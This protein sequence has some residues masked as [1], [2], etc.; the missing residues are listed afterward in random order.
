MT[1]QDYFKNYKKTSKFPFAFIS[2]D[3][4]TI[5]NFYND[6]IAPI[7]SDKAI[8]ANMIKWHQMLVEYSKRNN[9]YWVR[10]YESG[11]ANSNDNRRASLV[12]FNDGFKIL[13]VSNFDAQEIL[14][15][16]IMGV[17]PDLNEFEKLMK[18]HEYYF[19]YSQSCAENN[20]NSYPN[21]L[22]AKKLGVLT[23]AKYYLAHIRSV[24]EH[25][26]CINGM[27]YD[28][29]A[30]QNKSLHDHLYPKG[31]ETDYKIEKGSSYRVY[32]VDYSLN[33]DEKAIIKAHFLRFVDPLNYFP[34]PGENNHIYDYSD[35]SS[36]Y[37]NIGEFPFLISYMYDKMTSIFSGV[38]FLDFDQ[39]TCFDKAILEVND[40]N[41][42]VNVA[43]RAPKHYSFKR[44]TISCSKNNIPSKRIKNLSAKPVQKVQ[45]LNF[46]E[47]IKLEVVYWF[48]THKDALISIEKNILK[49]QKDQHGSKA[50][51]IL[52]SFGVKNNKKGILINKGIDDEINVSDGI[53]LE[54]LKKIKQ[55]F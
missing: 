42:V 22:N 19:H 14:N 2:K 49:L 48:L 35:G 3:Y 55:T 46:D 39:L 51:Y 40:P 37:K 33:N 34:V 9:I 26:Y 44:Q 13:Y 29:R 17:N 43:V 54:T 4:K 23:Q 38:N 27:Y 6:I 15:M 30:R 24:N 12:E 20:T 21:M 52:D 45:V 36:S 18:S 5:E 16:A 47:K 28:T 1:I 7:Y 25:S 41:L 11:G 32:K 31:K 8:V 50:K 10:Q 53:Y